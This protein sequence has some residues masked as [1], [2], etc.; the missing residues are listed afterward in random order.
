MGVCLSRPH[1]TNKGTEIAFLR[2]LDL[3]STLTLQNINLDVYLI[4]QFFYIIQ[5]VSSIDKEKIRIRKEN[6]RGQKRL[7]V[8]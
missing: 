8:S 6:R 5:S 4:H 2:G 1:D 3:N 7:K